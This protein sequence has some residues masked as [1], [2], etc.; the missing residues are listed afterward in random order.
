[1][2]LHCAWHAPVTSNLQPYVLFY[3]YFYIADNLYSGNSGQCIR[4]HFKIQL[5]ANTGHVMFYFRNKLL[6]VKG[7]PTNL[8]V[9]V[10][11]DQFE[12][13]TNHHQHK[14]SVYLR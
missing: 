11:G 12:L 6:I 10:K 13:K 2:G 5:R 14:W 8:T 3:W 1:M 4:Q 7:K 9:T